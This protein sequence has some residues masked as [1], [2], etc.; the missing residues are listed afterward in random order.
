MTSPALDRR[1]FLKASAT[2]AGG[3]LF[4]FSLPTPLRAQNAPG[5]GTAMADAPQVT[6]FLRI[7]PDGAIVFLNP[8]IEMGQGTYTAIPQIVAEELDAPLEAITVEQA[9][10]GDAYKVFNF[11]APLRFTGGSLSVRGAYMT[12]RKVGAGARAMLVAAATERFGVPAGELRTEAASV[13]HDASGRRA[14]YGDLAADAAAQTPRRR[15]RRKS[16]H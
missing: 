1:S 2:T 8:F 16:P 11:G 13:I 6:A 14:S 9:P 12:M 4:A 15:Q 3:V 10:H 7:D 5:S